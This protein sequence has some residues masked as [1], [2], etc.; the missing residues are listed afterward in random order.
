VLIGRREGSIAVLSHNGSIEKMFRIDGGI[1]SVESCGGYVIFGR[2]GMLARMNSEMKPVWTRDLAYSLQTDPVLLGGELWVPLRN[3]TIV[4]LSS[5]TGNVIT[6]YD[7]AGPLACPMATVGTG[8]AYSAED[9]I[10]TIV[11]RTGLED[12]A[13]LKVGDRIVGIA[14]DHGFLYVTTERGDLICCALD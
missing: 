4:R 12:S 8:M 13:R 2:N 10:I 11:N 5:E 14:G 9:G 7:L 1:Y 6:S 3:R